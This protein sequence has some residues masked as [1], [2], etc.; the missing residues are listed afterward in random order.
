MQRKRM[1]ERPYLDSHIIRESEHY[2]ALQAD[3]VST[4]STSSAT[5][6]PVKNAHQSIKELQVIIFQRSRLRFIR[7]FT[8]FSKNVIIFNYCNT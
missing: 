4:S 1:D 7:I 3:E 6:K 8:V 5:N 2:Y